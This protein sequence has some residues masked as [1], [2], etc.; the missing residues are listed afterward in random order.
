MFDGKPDIAWLRP[1]WRALRFYGRRARAAIE[2]GDS[3][4]KVAMIA[5]ADELLTLMTGILDTDA[6]TTL[7]PA[8]MTIYTALRYMLLRANVENSMAALDDFEAAL[9]LLDCEMIGP[10]RNAEAA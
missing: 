4:S 10:V 2:A 5:H 7:G 3:K 1:G 6:G 8:L 9:A